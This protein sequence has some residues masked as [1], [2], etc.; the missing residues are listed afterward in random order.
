MEDYEDEEDN[1]ADSTTTALC[2]T[3]GALYSFIGF[4][5]LLT[6]VCSF[7]NDNEKFL[8]LILMNFPPPL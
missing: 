4:I 3:L 7:C 2:Y 1:Y 5:C 8:G 6:L